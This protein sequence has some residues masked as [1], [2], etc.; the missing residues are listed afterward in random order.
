[1]QGFAGIWWNLAKY[2]LPAK[3]SG[4]SGPICRRSARREYVCVY[5]EQL[6]T[7]HG[8]IRK[9][10]ATPEEDLALARKRQKELMR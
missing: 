5:R 9:M 2:R 1:V 8:F 10:R 6:V 3:I 4:K 7:L